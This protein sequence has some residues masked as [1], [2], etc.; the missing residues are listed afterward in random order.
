[1]KILATSP[2]LRGIVARR[3]EE[4]GEGEGEGVEESDTVRKSIF[5]K[6]RGGLRE[7]GEG[8]KY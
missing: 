6:C 7:E 8:L 3:G 1:M 5:S 4:G 2:T